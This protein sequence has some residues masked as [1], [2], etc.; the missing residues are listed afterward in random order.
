MRSIYSFVL[1]LLFSSVAYSQFTTIGSAFEQSSGS[2]QCFQLTP[3]TGYHQVGAVWNNTPIDLTKNFVVYSRLYFGKQD[4]GADGIAFVLQNYG[5]TAIGISGGGLGY[6]QMPGNSF[7]IEFD[8]Y[9]NL[10][11]NFTTGDPV[12]DHIGFM[13]QGNAFHNASTALAAPYPLPQ[14]IEDDQYHDAKFT[15]NASSQT[16]TL[17]FLGQTFSYSGDIVHTIFGGNSTVYWGFTAATGSDISLSGATQSQQ[18]VC[19]LPP[20]T[21]GQLRTQTPGGWGAKPHGNNPGTY[22]YAHFATAFPSGLTVGVNPDYHVSF[23]SAQSIT[24]Y[25]PAGGPAKKLTQNYTNPKTTDLKNVLVDHLVAL[26]LSVGFDDAD[27]DFGQ[28]GITLGDMQIGSGP[29]ANWTVRAFLAEA[30]KVLGGTSTYTVQQALETAA[31]INENYTDGT[32]DKG[33]LI[34]P[35]SNT[36]QARARIEAATTMMEGPQQL[37]QVYPNP[38]RNNFVMQPGSL[39][40]SGKLVITS[41]NGSIVEQRTI[42]VTGGQPIRLNLNNQRA[43]LYFV[44]LITSNGEQVQKLLIQK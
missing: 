25:L 29:F 15:W 40:G 36:Q 21:C 1:A 43:G 23:T 10:Q 19:I 9:Q 32:T 11:W 30:N 20:P 5:L 14:N 35:N 3:P 17:S 16:M 44:K 12:E 27:P 8:T 2:T 39:Y 28:A 38:G 37:M 42:N 18:I 22:L 34:C 13:S 6:H 41:S 4:N 24:N 31:A 26:T 7:I 33:Y